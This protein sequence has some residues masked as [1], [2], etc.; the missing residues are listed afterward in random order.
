VHTKESKTETKTKEMT[1]V[2][3]TT[4]FCPACGWTG[5]CKTNCSRTTAQIRYAQRTAYCARIMLA[6]A[7]NDEQRGYW[8][9]RLLWAEASIKACSEKHLQAA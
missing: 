5:F 4:E 2:T 6:L 1:T 9:G 8:S 7:A 3:T